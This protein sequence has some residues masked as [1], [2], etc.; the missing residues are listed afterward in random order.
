MHL[1]HLS[2]KHRQRPRSLLYN[3]LYLLKALLAGR[4]PFPTLTIY[5]KNPLNIN[6]LRN[7]SV[8]SPNRDMSSAFCPPSAPPNKKAGFSM[9]GGVRVCDARL[10]AL[11]KGAPVDMP[12]LG[13]VEVDTDMSVTP[14]ER[15]GPGAPSLHLVR[16][17]GLGAKAAVVMEASMLNEPISDRDLT[18]RRFVAVSISL[19]INL[20]SFF[21][22]FLASSRWQFVVPSRPHWRRTIQVDQMQGRSLPLSAAIDLGRGWRWESHY[23]A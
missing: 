1:L 20:T 4:C 8:T 14:N 9:F 11:P 15:R 22:F 10:P 3:N 23:R 16:A 17:A 5:R 6:N 12:I 18:P 19:Q 13:A 2:I 21:S 7:S